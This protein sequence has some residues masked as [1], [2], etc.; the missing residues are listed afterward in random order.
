ML[1]KHSDCSVNKELCQLY[2]YFC[3]RPVGTASGHVTLW[4]GEQC[5]HIDDYWEQ[6]LKYSGPCNKLNRVE[7]GAPIRRLLSSKKILISK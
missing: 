7:M 4:N 6:P 2:L 5:H 3:R 1:Y